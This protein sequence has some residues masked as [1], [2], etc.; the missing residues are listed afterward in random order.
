MHFENS[1]H[2]QSGDAKKPNMLDAIRDL[3]DKTNDP[4]NC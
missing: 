1:V 3:L 4:I 2:I